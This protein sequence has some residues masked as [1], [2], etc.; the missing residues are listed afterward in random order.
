MINWFELLT[1]SLWIFALALVLAVLSY[2]RWETKIGK[3]RFKDLLNR[4][5][6]VI[7]INLA[8]ALFCLALALLD[9]AWWE[10]VLWGI[11]LVY[12]AARIW[13]ARNL[14]DK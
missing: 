9:Q 2:T 7:L 1:N 5:P 13:T 10:R 11:L 4:S 12:F 14:A 8:G 3:G 6:R